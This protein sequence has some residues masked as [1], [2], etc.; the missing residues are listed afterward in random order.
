MPEKH[1]NGQ[2]LGANLLKPGIGGGL[3]RFKR[4]DVKSWKLEESDEDKTPKTPMSP[5]TKLNR[6]Q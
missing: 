5:Q 3:L 6:M 4:S 1:A 2:Q